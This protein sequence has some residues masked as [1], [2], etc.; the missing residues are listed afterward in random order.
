MMHLRRFALAVGLIELIV[1]TACST[2]KS[3]NPTAPLSADEFNIARNDV[4]LPDQADL[5]KI[6]QGKSTGDYPQYNCLLNDAL[7]A[8]KK[9]HVCR[10]EIVETLLNQGATAAETG[11]DEK[12]LTN[13][14]CHHEYDLTLAYE[15]FCLDTV[16]LIAPHLSL[17]E[18]LEA[19]QNASWKLSK[20]KTGTADSEQIH[21]VVLAT[22]AYRVTQLQ[23][24]CKSGDTLSCAA[25]IALSH[26]IDDDRQEA[27]SREEQTRKAAER[28]K[29][30]E[31]Q[32]QKFQEENPDPDSEAGII[33]IACEASAG[34]QQ[35]DQMRAHEL[36]VGRESGYVNK[37][38]LHEYAVG[39]L[40][41]EHALAKTKAAYLAKFKKAL[42]L[43]TCRYEPLD[44]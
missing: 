29:I 10:T 7:A 1:G 25:A 14:F 44:I 37:N 9:D 38:A 23:G 16:K 3:F 31:E 18:R 33:K 34:I 26:K 12:N 24:P 4:N 40:A 39:K 32:R 43:K 2:L 35:M 5:Q 30:N 20:S 17:Q 42:S 28:E 6:L 21:Q 19:A 27:T 41:S 22:L 8:A 13:G 15:S 11:R 36:A